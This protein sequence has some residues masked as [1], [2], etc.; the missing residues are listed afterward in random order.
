VPG[1]DKY[2]RDNVDY[3][4]NRYEVAPELRDRIAE[5]WGAVIRRYGYGEEHAA[6]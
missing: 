2:L 6:D 3:K 1:L 5:R 4:S